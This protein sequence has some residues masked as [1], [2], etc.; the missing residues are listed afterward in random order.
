MTDHGPGF[1]YQFNAQQYAPNQGGDGGKH[2]VGKHQATIVDTEVKET[3]AKT[4]HYLAVSYS[5]PQGSIVDRFNIHNPS[6][7]AVRIGHEQLSALCH[8]TGVFQVDMNNHGAALRGAR[9]MIE[10]GL[11]KEPNPNGYTEVKKRFDV[12]GNEPGKPPANPAN[13]GFTA[14]GGFTP[15]QQPNAMPQQFQQPNPN[16]NPA[17]Q[18][19]GWG[20][21]NPNPNPAQQPTQAWGQPNSQPQQQPN[22]QPAAW[23]QPT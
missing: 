10:V 12:N 2:P 7:D 6:A 3:D 19:N 21:P 13:N 18:N 4:G 17:P 23:G 11:Q 15:Q 22:P 20:Q 14:P 8:A 16:P 1:N 5:T 9:L